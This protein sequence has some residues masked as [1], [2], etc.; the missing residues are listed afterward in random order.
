MTIL[1]AVKA[2]FGILLVVGAILFL[3][4]A[5]YRRHQ[6]AVIAALGG[7]FPFAAGIFMILAAFGISPGCPGH[8]LL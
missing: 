6:W 1:C 3:T 8:K 2:I 4:Y 5:F 7:F